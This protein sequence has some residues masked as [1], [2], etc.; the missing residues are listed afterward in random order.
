MIAQ[1][2]QPSQN[3]RRCNV[4]VEDGWDPVAAGFQKNGFGTLRPAHVHEHG[5]SLADLVQG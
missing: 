3:F 2:D 5:G 4:R 1:G